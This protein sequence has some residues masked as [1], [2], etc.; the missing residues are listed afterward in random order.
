MWE[1]D[2]DPFEEMDRR[3]HA[4]LRQAV[5]GAHSELFDIDSKSLKPL[6]R[7]E[8]RDDHVTVTFDLPYVRKEDISLTSTEDVLSIEAKMRKPV[9]LKL[10]GSIQRHFE[11][12]RFSKKIRLPA[13]V[14]TEGARAKFHNG[15]LVVEYGVAHRG[16]PVEI[17]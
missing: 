6:Y 17:K 3:I 11:F 7:I 1:D 8:V 9:T 12:E 15:M 5:S 14:D 4:I 16:N 10:G 13:R 2:Y